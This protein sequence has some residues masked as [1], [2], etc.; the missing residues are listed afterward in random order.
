MGCF[1]SC[2][3]LQGRF[4]FAVAQ[5]RR[6]RLLMA[7]THWWVDHIFSNIQAQCLRIFLAICLGVLCW[8]VSLFKQLSTVL[9]HCRCQAAR[10]C[11]KRAD[12]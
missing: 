11:L 4:L 10:L 3:Y 12:E 6:W 5:A 8:L 1:I 2:A 7:D 9:V